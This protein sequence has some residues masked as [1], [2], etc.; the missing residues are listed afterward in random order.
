MIRRPPRSTRTDTLFPYTTLFRSVDAVGGEDLAAVGTERERHELAFDGVR[1]GWLPILALVVGLVQDVGVVVG[2]A[3]GEARY[4]AR[5]VHERHV[6]DADVVDQAMRAAL[7]IHVVAHRATAFH[8][9][10]AHV[11]KYVPDGWHA[12]DGA[13]YPD[14]AGITDI[15]RE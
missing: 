7:G 8:G 12:F 3:Q 10:V 13:D 11:D 6:L 4:H 5:V 15:D 1:G 2:G 9:P 14:Q